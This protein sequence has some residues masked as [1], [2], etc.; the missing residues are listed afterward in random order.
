AVDEMP[1]LPR[2]AIGKSTMTGNGLCA[3][4]LVAEH[5]LWWWISSKSWAAETG[6]GLCD[7][8]VAE[9]GLW[10]WISSKSRAAENTSGDQC[11]SAL[12]GREGAKLDFFATLV[13]VL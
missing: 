4:G 2:R 11:V 8:L 12:I 6:N 7:G 9:H 10:W 3:D 5:D 1:P 13:S